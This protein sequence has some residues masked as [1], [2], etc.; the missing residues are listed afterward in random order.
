M[1]VTFNPL[2]STHSG[3]MSSAGMG[4]GGY[5]GWGGG[6]GALYSARAN[7]PNSARPGDGQ[8]RHKVKQRGRENVTG[9]AAPSRQLPNLKLEGS[10]GGSAD[11]A[12]SGGAAGAA[13][14]HRF[15]RIRLKLASCRLLERQTKAPK[16]YASA[17][18][19]EPPELQ[20]RFSASRTIKAVSFRLILGTRFF[21]SRWRLA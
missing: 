2:V 7:V 16:S 18:M 17:A 15:T 14:G 4:G 13:G 19:A 20:V 3:L 6:I 8:R 10:A 5:D 21:T 1:G 12:A 9:L 11:L